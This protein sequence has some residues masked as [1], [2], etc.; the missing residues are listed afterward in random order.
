MG[1]KRGAAA[2]QPEGVHQAQEQA[3]IAES[4][5]LQIA[6]AGRLR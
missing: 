5:K 1:K 3:S 2:I 4:P 6:L